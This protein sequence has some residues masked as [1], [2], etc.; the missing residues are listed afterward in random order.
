MPVLKPKAGSPQAREKGVAA[1]GGGSELLLD[2]SALCPS[3]HGWASSA[4][5][6]CLA[7]RPV[8]G[9]FLLQA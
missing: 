4:A 7:L 2:G 3:P 9:L 1:E 5:R 6:V 8:F